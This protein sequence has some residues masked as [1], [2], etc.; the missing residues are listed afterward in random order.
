MSIDYLFSPFYIWWEAEPCYILI[1]LLVV[2]VFLCSL[3]FQEFLLQFSN[4]SLGVS[5]FLHLAVLDSFCRY[6]PS[7][8][9]ALLPF[10]DFSSST[11][12]S[13]CLWKIVPL[14][15]LWR[16]ALLC[17]CQVQQTTVAS[18]ALILAQCDA[19]KLSEV[20]PV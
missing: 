16:L 3:A 7:P 11:S 19:Q 18:Q 12:A 2:L 4:C 15:Y 14:H 6:S 8:C 10:S 17:S 9:D 1:G 20:S 13:L 5:S